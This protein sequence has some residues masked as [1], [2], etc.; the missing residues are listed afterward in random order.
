MKIKYYLIIVIILFTVSQIF[1]VGNF[2]AYYTKVN[3]DDGIRGKYAHVI[4][5]Y[6]EKGDIIFSRETSYLPVWKTN[7]N[8]LVEIK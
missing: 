6:G 5:S 1:A 4:I 2:Y 3:Y 7:A 8:R